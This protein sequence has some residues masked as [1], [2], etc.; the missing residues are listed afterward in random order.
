F[1]KDEI[2]AAAFAQNPVYYIFGA[3]GALLTAF[4]MFRLYATTFLGSFRGTEDQKHHL[5]ESPASM[6]IPLIV[7]AVLSIVGGWIGIP[8]VLMK[9]GH[10]LEQFLSPVFAHS[11]QVMKLRLDH[12]TSHSTE[13]ILMA[14]T[15]I[16][17][18]AALFIA[19]SRYRRNP[20][21][22]EP[23]GF[24]KV[25]ANKWYVDEFYHFIIVRPVYALA[26]FLNTFVERD[27]IDWIVNGVG[28]LIHYISRQVRL[29][30]SGQVG[31]YVLLMV[32]SILVFFVLQIFI[33]K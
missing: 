16:G 1:S 18:A 30:Q 14:I 21:L 3:A 15:V 24:G 20:E 27:F 10:S 2:L 6:T 28:R 29:V 33:K 32:L 5:H 8:E 12:E 25:L 13:Y 9:G 17:A 7:L 22:G 4:Y 26:K 31:S 11:E 23:S 19:T